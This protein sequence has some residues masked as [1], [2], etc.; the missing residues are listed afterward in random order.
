LNIKLRQAAPH[1]IA[2]IAELHSKSWRDNYSEVLSKDYLNTKVLNERLDVWTSRLSQPSD[3]QMVLVA[4][5]NDLFCGFICAYANRHAE[6]G[7]IVDNLHVGSNM[8]GK[9][10][11]T[12]LLIAIADW[13]ESNYKGAGIY[14]EVLE[15]NRKAIGYYESLGATRKHSSYWLTPCGNRAKEYI[16]GWSSSKALLNSAQN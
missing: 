9:G 16:Y 3:N 13:S 6:Y 4:E 10:V 1:D 7:T 11:G 8:K 2:N 14:L 12:R 5:S 15:C